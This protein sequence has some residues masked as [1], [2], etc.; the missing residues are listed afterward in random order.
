MSS[1]YLKNKIAKIKKMICGTDI[2]ERSSNLD[3][4]KKYFCDKNTTNMK[5]VIWGAGPHTT[6]LFEFFGDYLPNV[7]FLIDN[8]ERLQNLRPHNKNVY[9]SNHLINSCEEYDFVLV[10]TF[11][12]SNRDEMRSYLYD[13]NIECEVLDVYE[14]LEETGIDTSISA[15]YKNDHKYISICNNLNSFYNIVGNVDKEKCLREIIIGYLEIKDLNNCIKYSELYIKKQYPEYQIFISVLLELKELL[16]FIMD[17][18]EKIQTTNLILL[19]C[20]G[21]NQKD[22]DCSEWKKLVNNSFSFSNACSPSLA[23]GASIF[24]MFSET[25]PFENSINDNLPNID[26]SKTYKK[27]KLK[28]YKNI[29]VYSNTDWDIITGA[30]VK[31]R[32]LDELLAPNTIWE[33]LCDIIDNA[34]KRENEIYLLY[35]LTESHE[36]C[37]CPEL[38]HKPAFIRPPFY[39]FKTEL[40]KEQYYNQRKQAVRY[41]G[42]QINYLINLLNDNQTSILFSD[43]GHFYPHPNENLCTCGTIL[44]WHSDRYNVPL[45]IFNKRIN[46][47]KER[48]IFSLTDFMKLI[49]AVVEKSEIKFENK[50][51]IVQQF[52]IYNSDHAERYISIGKS[53]YTMGFTI[54]ISDK[55]KY[56][57]TSSLCGKSYFYDLINEDV[58]IVNTNIAQQQI[59]NI[60]DSVAPFIFNANCRTIQ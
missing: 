13:N 26:N 53:E 38:A 18:L 59:Q 35:F 14:A 45:M 11:H 29:T 56:V 23:S 8:S 9:S 22:T 15:F 47:R 17:T 16:E 7:P 52:P 51:T 60:F 43:H 28:G 10:S 5:V 30:L 39:Q 4:I 2:Q 46:Y 31:H 48:K 20:D 21:L 44:G 24:S 37:I 3:I 54:F 27:L 40:T 36:P 49:L 32:R 19:Y 33:F 12:K 34:S 50:Y 57:V 58:D 55:Y 41:L 6:K 25:N 1:A 42:M